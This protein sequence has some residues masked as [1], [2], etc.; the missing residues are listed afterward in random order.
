MMLIRCIHQEV[1][2]TDMEIREIRS[3]NTL[4]EGETGEIVQVRGKPETHRYL[5]NKGLAMGRRISINS[6]ANQSPDSTLVI[7]SGDV[8]SSIGKDLAGSIKVRLV[9]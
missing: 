8:V 4:A 5:F 6:A 9:S 3:L 1:T 2:I 7:R